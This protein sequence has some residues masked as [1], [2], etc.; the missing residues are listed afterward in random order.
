MLLQAHLL[1]SFICS[2][3]LSRKSHPNKSLSEFYANFINTNGL[4]SSSDSRILYTP[5]QRVA[6][7]FMTIA[8][9]KEA[10][11][12]HFP[13]T[14]ESGDKEKSW[15][16]VEHK[17][18]IS[19]QVLVR[20]IRNSITHGYTELDNDFVTFLDRKDRKPNETNF[21][22]LA[23]FSTESLF[24]LQMKIAKIAAEQ[25]CSQP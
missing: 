1:G 11:Y 18:A 8:F 7:M 12:Q 21:D 3:E 15:G 4:D 10:F 2:F 6:I 24:V 14:Y 13:S 20:R 25:S 5:G 22:F 19:P 23:K 17:G 9:Q 16:V